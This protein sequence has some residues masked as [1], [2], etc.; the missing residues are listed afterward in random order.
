MANLVLGGP[1]ETPTKPF[2]LNV[3]YSRTWAAPFC[4]GV[5]PIWAERIHD[6][7]KRVEQRFGLVVSEER[8]AWDEDTETI[9]TFVTVLA[10]LKGDRI[11][12]GQIAR[13]TEQVLQ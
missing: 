10:I 8:N 4:H 7:W 5:T 3:V 6:Y 2:R 12:A 9:T 11:P 1:Y 13:P